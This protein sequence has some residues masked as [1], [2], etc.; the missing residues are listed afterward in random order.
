MTGVEPVCR[1]FFSVGHVLSFRSSLCVA[2]ERLP[3]QGPPPP[4]VLHCYLLPDVYHSGDRRQELGFLLFWLSINLRQSLGLRDV[5]FSMLLPLP[6]CGSGPTQTPRV[7]LILVPTPQCEGSLPVPWG[8]ELF[9]PFALLPVS[10]GRRDDRE[11]VLAE[12]LAP[13]VAAA[14]LLKPS[15]KGCFLRNL[16]YLL[17][18]LSR[19]CREKPASSYSTPLTCAASPGHPIP[20]LA[21]F[22]IQPSLQLCQRNSHLCP[23]SLPQEA[24]AHGS[25]CRHLFFLRPP[26]TGCPVT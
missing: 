6:S 19:V 9:P 12:F 21:T 13:S 16:T 22:S 17:G 15:T 3:W 26:A 2:P 14:L 11:R 4:A 23:G 18:T 7:G 20:L 24:S 10:R 1:G 25:L 5:A 8:T